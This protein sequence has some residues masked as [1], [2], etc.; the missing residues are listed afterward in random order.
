MKEIVE[1]LASQL[2]VKQIYEDA[3]KPAA[4]QTGAIGEDIMKCLHLV[5]AP[6]QYGAGVRSKPLSLRSL[7][8]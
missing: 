7:C 3:G 8:D 5:L 4:K 2:P 6:V 1:E